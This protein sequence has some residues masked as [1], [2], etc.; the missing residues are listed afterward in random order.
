M[1]QQMSMSG[2]WTEGG[3]KSSR[4]LLWR[5]LF[6]ILALW[7]FPA[8][9]LWWGFGS[10]D[11]FHLQQTT[12]EE[13]IRLESEV[14]SFSR[15]CDPQVFFQKYFTKLF[16]ELKS[17]PARREAL[18]LVVKGFQR[19]WPKGLVDIYLF[20][21]DGKLLR[22]G[23]PPPEIQ[24][25]FD[26]ARAP[27]TVPL[28]IQ[29]KVSAQLSRVIPSPQPLLEAL[30]GR[31]GRVIS[32]GANR[33]FSFGF[34]NLGSG[35]RGQR[36]AG[37]LAFVHVEALPRDLIL[38]KVQTETGTGEFGFAL[39][40]DPAILPAVATGVTGSEVIQKFHLEPLS[41]FQVASFL[42]VVK[43]ADQSTLL[44][45]AVAAPTGWQL[46][47]FGIGVAY[48]AG[49]F[50]MLIQSYRAEVL[51]VRIPVALRTKILFYYSLSF[52]LPVIA[53]GFLLWA[54][55]ADKRGSF[56]DASRQESFRK[57]EELDRGFDEF[58]S[59]K[60][61]GFRLLSRSMK[62]FVASPG[63][64]LAEAER[65]FDAFA[66][67]NIHIVG[68]DGILLVMQKTT[69]VEQRRAYLLPYRQRLSVFNS[70]IE[71][72]AAMPGRDILYMTLENQAGIR[73][74]AE[75]E[76]FQG[77]LRKAIVQGGLI[78]ID[79]FNRSNGLSAARP[80]KASQLALETVME[81]ESMGLFE[82]ARRGLRTFVLLEGNNEL[83]LIYID[84]LPGPAGEGWY[85]EFIFNN[86]LNFERGYLEATLGNGPGSTTTQLPGEEPWDCRAISRHPTT[87]NFPGIWEFRKFGDVFTHMEASR[88]PLAL[89]MV[90]DGE[91]SDICA[92]QCSF[93]KHYILVAV[94]PRSQLDNRFAS[95]ENSVWLCFAGLVAFGVGLSWLLIKRF[96]SPVQDLTRGL[97]AMSGKDFDFRIP[98]RSGDELGRLCAAFN[99]AISKLKDME[100]AHAV[101]ADLLPQKSLRFGSYEVMG[102]NIM[103]QSVGGDY[104][105][106]IPLPHGLVAVVMGDVSGHGVSAALVSAMA[107]AA[108][109]IL[110][111]RLFDRPEEILLLINKALLTQLKRAKMMTCF[112]GILDPQNDCII[113]SNAGQTY[114]LLVGPDG[115]VSVIRLPSNPLG[116]RTKMT[117]SRQVVSLK[118]SVFVLYSDGLVE[119]LNDQ[120]KVFGYDAIGTAVGKAVASKNPDILGNVLGQ[121]R[122][123]TGSVPWGDDATMV[124]IRS[125]LDLPSWSGQ[126]P[127]TQ[128]RPPF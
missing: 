122:D 80:Q 54:F 11:Q 95:F 102:V 50:L 65:G 52:A 15:K 121:V 78:A 1:N 6:R 79:Q 126:K 98:V 69:S 26:L 114:P 128:N 5:W 92:L 71:R 87:P 103:T 32:L 34:F 84:V 118:G 53:V 58:L 48:L 23:N 93:M 73:P 3:D 22:V 124:V 108:F 88:R 9:F 46:L 77:M 29:P 91:E 19:D 37:L 36:V 111:P 56:L 61:N 41:R 104:F 51:G 86:I 106:F 81:S 24:L 64:L 66:W 76:V 35:I 70:W 49:S 43:R 45:G 33:R 21:G 100:I 55:L 117:S 89:S 44:V 4:K 96:L 60:L 7:G 83:G 127:G 113:C 94:T 47:L 107:K 101:Q 40:G 62:A 99:E 17:V 112:L 30:K 90:V 72:G 82:A 75:T 18:E 38:R 119:A 28:V 57:L 97:S 67:D 115:K 109:S 20:S 2:S 12:Q 14:E 120:R 63:Y 31:P 85:A 42:F 59:R 74:V 10:L 39:E 27:W 123:Y 68:S 16:E 13:F 116:V 25:L 8:F 105:D 125:L 110:C